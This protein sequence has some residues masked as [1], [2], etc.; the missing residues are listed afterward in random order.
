[1]AETSEDIAL[2]RETVRRFLRARLLPLEAAIEAADEADPALLATLRRE[3]AALGLY[4]FNLPVELGG[5]GLSVAARVALA[6]EIGHASMPLT[7]VFGHLPLSLTLLNEEQRTRILPALRDGTETV[8]YALTEPG[9]GSDLS[10]LGT[11][12]RRVPGGWVLNGTKQFISNVETADWI[13]LLAA[14]HPEA[15]LKG[16]LTTFLLRRDNPGLQGLVRYRKMVWRGY[17]LNGFVLQDAFVPDADLLGAPGG[18]FLAMMAGIN[19]D[20]V[21]VACRCL[22]I[23]LR[24]QAMAV[25][26]A[27]ERIA[28][29]AKLADHQA[30]Q[31]MLADNDVEIEAAR[32]LIRRAAELADAGAAE[33]RIAAA[34][35]KLYASEMVNRVADRALQVFGASGTMCD[36]PL[37]RFYR[38]ARAFRIGEGT[39]EMQR[40]QIARHALGGGG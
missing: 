39:S 23:A 15:P 3:V 24:A 34:R 28:F 37:E 18:G 21:F 6:E 2:L 13:I 30:V 14:T 25:A 7:E 22:G 26:Q 36:L 11:R 19:H 29:G 35:A 16:R 4:G 20:R 1:V 38:D 17:T 9:A 8:T 31:F 40:I 33:F 27:G 10:A 5:P 12:G 32:G